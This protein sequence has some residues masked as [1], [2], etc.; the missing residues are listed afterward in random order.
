ME[1][2]PIGGPQAQ[3][4]RPD[5][6]FHPAALKHLPLLQTYPLEAL[7]TN[8][9]GTANVLTAAAEAGVG[10]FANIS[11]NKA[12]DP[13]C[14]LGYSKRLAERLTADFAHTQLGRYVSV[15]FGNVLGSRGSVV[16]A[17]AGQIGR[18]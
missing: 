6:V 12:A 18:A 3:H 8:V 14:V 15:R 13:T 1:P 4:S 17:F 2:E 16:H 9:L 11:T 5:I 7:K 10:T